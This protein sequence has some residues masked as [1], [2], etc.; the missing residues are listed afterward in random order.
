MKNYRT[1]IMGAARLALLCTLVTTGVA[2][3]AGATTK[4]ASTKSIEIVENADV[5]KQRMTTALD[6]YFGALA[7]H[8]RLLGSI[9]LYQDGK[10]IYHRALVPSDDSVAISRDQLKYKVGSITKTFTAT[11]VLQLVEEGKLSLE[12]KLATFYPNVDNADK[13]TIGHML[14]H[15][16][17][18]HNYTDEPDF[19]NYYQTH[20]EKAVL[21]EKIESFD[22]DF[23]PGEKAAYSNSNYLLLGYILEHVTD[24]SYAELL[25]ER[26]YQPL[27]MTNTLLGESINTEN[28]EVYSYQIQDKK[29]QQVPEWDMSVA[30]SAGAIVSTTRDLDIFIRGLFEGKLL[31]K[32]SLDRMLELENGFGQGIFGTKYKHGEKELQG[33]WHNGGIEAFVSHLAYYPEVDIS[34]VVLTNGLNYDIRK[35]YEA[36]L[37]AYFGKEVPVPEFGKVVDLAPELLEPLQGHYKSETHPLDISITLVDKQLYAQATGQG[38]FPLSALDENNFEFVK[39]GIEIRF[40]RDSDMFEIKQGGR[41]DVFI[42][43]TNAEKEKSIDVP[44]KILKQYVGTYQA[45]NFPLDIEIMIKNGQLY[46]QATGQSAFPLTPISHNKFK[47]TLADIVI[48]FDVEKRHL[49]ITQRGQPRIL[50]KQ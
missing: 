2:T 39:A 9:A 37:D 43:V 17:G 40:D 1:G 14:N 23:E 25:A 7:E 29:W 41:A 32:S 4:A 47:F 46:A 30:Y 20:Q 35:V 3:I 10:E 38:G 34:V 13:I 24:K 33:Y 22:A 16:S 15:H 18:I 21:V 19:M 48:E 8:D 50:Q 12:T 49:T 28:A 36:L 6:P 44:E 5:A 45:D 42:K 27:G 31:K 26:I 11:L